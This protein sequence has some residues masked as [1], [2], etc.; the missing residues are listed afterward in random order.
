MTPIHKKKIIIKRKKKETL[1]LPSQVNS[2]FEKKE[3]KIMY[4]FKEI[5]NV[6]TF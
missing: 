1:K 6:K 2:G 3:S 4:F 5:I